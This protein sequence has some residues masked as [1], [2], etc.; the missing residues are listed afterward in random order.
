MDKLIKLKIIVQ[1]LSFITQ[2]SIKILKFH[3]LKS[4]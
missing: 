3:M 1:N 4:V 2:L